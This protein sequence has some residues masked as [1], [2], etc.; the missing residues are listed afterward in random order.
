MRG[1]L[2]QSDPLLH[3]A[4]SPRRTLASC[5]SLGSCA[6]LRSRCTA[7]ARRQTVAAALDA[8]ERSNSDL[9]WA[10]NYSDTAVALP[11]VSAPAAIVRDKEGLHHGHVKMSRTS[12]SCRGGSMRATAV[13]W[14]RAAVALTHRDARCSASQHD[15]PRV[16]H[17]SAMRSDGLMG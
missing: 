9:P 11:D 17:I 6:A 3:V 14:V 2:V 12:S 4:M 5:A 13:P 16:Q 1:L 8:D 7:R 10:G 15:A